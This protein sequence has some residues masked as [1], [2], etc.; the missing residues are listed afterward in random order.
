MERRREEHREEEEENNTREQHKGWRKEKQH[1]EGRTKN[2][3]GGEGLTLTRTSGMLEKWVNAPDVQ[4]PNH[5]L[6]Q[7]NTATQIATST[8]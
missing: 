8:P 7:K 5:M 2:N 3:T 6:Q 1:K 4:S